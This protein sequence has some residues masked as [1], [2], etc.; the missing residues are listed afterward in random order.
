MVGTELAELAA[1]GATALV[2]AVATDLWGQVRDRVGRLLTRGRESRVEAARI[3]LA[4]AEVLDAEENE[5]P[6]VRENVRQDWE[7]R[8]LTV[9]REDPTAVAE[10]RALLDEIAPQGGGS[11]IEVTTIHNE[12]SA[13][14]HGIA[15]QIGRVG[16]NN[17]RVENPGG[18]PS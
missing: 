6:E 13:D 17:V 10:L 4:Y 12:I 15:L 16:T 11:R 18:Q 9:L 8:L 2:G 7:Q 1:S 3:E 14:V 5:L